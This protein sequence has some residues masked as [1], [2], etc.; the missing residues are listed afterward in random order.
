MQFGAWG[1]RSM[2]CQESSDLFANFSSEFWVL[3][4]IIKG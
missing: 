1:L 3:D 2:V 4:L